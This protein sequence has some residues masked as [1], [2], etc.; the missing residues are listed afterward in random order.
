M[1]THTSIPTAASS[2]TVVAV[3]IAALVVAL[4]TLMSLP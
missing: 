3:T 2:R 4:L 1:R